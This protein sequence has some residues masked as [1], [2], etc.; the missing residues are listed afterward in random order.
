MK[1]K[2]GGHCIFESGDA[3]RLCI[4]GGAPVIKLMNSYKVGQELLSMSPRPLIIGRHYVENEPPN[5]DFLRHSPQDIARLYVSWMETDIRSNPH[6]DAWEGPNEPAFGDGLDPVGRARLLWYSQFEIERTRILREGFGKASM[7]GNF[8]TGTPDLPAADRMAGWRPFIPAIDALERYNGYL[9]LHEYGGPDR[10]MDG[11]LLLR[12]RWILNEM[13]ARGVPVKIVMTECGFDSTPGNPPGDS[14]KGLKLTPERYAQYLIWYNEE[15]LKDREVVGGTLFTYGSS[16]GWPDFDLEGT[17]VTQLLI[18]YA[19][20]GQE[21]EEML[22]AVSRFKFKVRSKKDTPIYAS[23]GENFP[24]IR[25]GKHYLVSGRIMDISVIAGT[26]FKVYDKPAMW[27][28]QA[29]C[30]P[31]NVMLAF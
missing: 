25:N 7:I 4:E 30:E 5:D 31:L 11:W 12:Y 3:Q 29:D 26:W 13:R 22:V 19:Q 9:G 15:L 1:L 6:I 17:R 24:L 8:S 20:Q 10:T 23:P 2:L 16:T 27:V 18:D 21:E 14:W 28:R